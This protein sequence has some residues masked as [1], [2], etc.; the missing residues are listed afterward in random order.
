MLPPVPGLASP[1]EGTEMGAFDQSNNSVP[2]V[3]I[4]HA[5]FEWKFSLNREIVFP[6]VYNYVGKAA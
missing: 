3:S 1:K 4:P 2:S 6:A 5:G